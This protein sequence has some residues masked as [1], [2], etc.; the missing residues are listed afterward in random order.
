MERAIHNRIVS[1]ENWLAAR[2]LL[3]EK[4]KELTWRRDQ[5]SLERRELPWM[6]VDKE[7]IFDGPDGNVRLAELFGNRSQLVINHI[8]PDPGWE[9]GQT[10]CSFGAVPIE[11]AL[12][13]LEH[14]E[15]SYVAVSRAPLSEIEAFKKR[16]GW[17]FKWVSSLGSDFTEEM[18]GMNLFYQDESE[19]VYHT[20]SAY[21]PG[22][23]ELAR[24]YLYLDV[25]ATGT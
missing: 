22:A 23:E 21:G 19:D 15:I 5:L 1:R 10:G 9:E 7:Y 8:I 20:Y 17:R 6:R 12:T 3:L 11:S 25:A 18:P 16:M 13:Y 14:Q 2:R 4:E 24:T